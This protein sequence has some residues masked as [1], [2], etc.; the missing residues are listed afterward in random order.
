MVP[1]HNSRVQEIQQVLKDA[2][3]DLGSVDG[4]MGAQT[5]GAIR[6]FQ[7]ANQLRPTGKIDSATLSVLNREKEVLEHE[8]KIGVLVE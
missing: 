6:E 2:D 1:R 8:Q 4:M 7:K 3:F 5:K